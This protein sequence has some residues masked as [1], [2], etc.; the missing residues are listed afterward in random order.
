MKRNN[1]TQTN[2]LE[3]ARDVGYG[4]RIINKDTIII[5]TDYGKEITLILDRKEDSVLVDGK[6]YKANEDKKFFDTFP[7]KEIIKKYG[8]EYNPFCNIFFLFK[9]IN[10]L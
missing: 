7:K 10:N 9:F 2:I 8:E 5:W 6:K 3:F 4:Y 1:F